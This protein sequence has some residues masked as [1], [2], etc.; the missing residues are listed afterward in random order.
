MDDTDRPWFLEFGSHKIGT[1]DPVEMTLTEIELP[2]T[3]ARPRRM[4]L[5]SDQS[6]WY[7]DYA[8]GMLGRYNPA[9]EEFTE[10]PMPSGSNSRPYGV[11]SDDEDRIWFVET[12]PQPNKFIGFDSRTEEF[13]SINEVESGGGTIRHMFFD[14]ATRS[15]WFGADANTIGVARLGQPGS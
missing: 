5:T 2:R 8:G 14:P 11:A 6:V 9:T 13:V 15:I 1:V 12:G 7:V 3:E 4:A 10:W